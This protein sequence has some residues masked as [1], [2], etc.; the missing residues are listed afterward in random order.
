MRKEIQKVVC[1][2]N[3]GARK[4][5]R[6]NGVLMHEDTTG[7]MNEFFRPL[8]EL[9]GAIAMGS[10][11][12]ISA[13][14]VLVSDTEIAT[15]VRND[16]IDNI[17]NNVVITVDGKKHHFIPIFPRSIYNIFY[18]F[19]NDFL[20]PLFHSFLGF[21]DY[22]FDNKNRFRIPDNF[23]KNFE[24][25][26]EK[27]RQVANQFVE[28]FDDQAVCWVHDY[29]FLLIPEY[30]R[31]QRPNQ[32]V[33]FFLHIPFPPVE[34][35]NLF[36]RAKK[37]LSGMLGADYI[38]FHLNCYR[39]NF[40]ST[41]KRF[42]SENIIIKEDD[43][44]IYHKDQKTRRIKVDVNPIGIAYQ[45]HSG[46]QPDEKLKYTLDGLRHHNRQLLLSMSR[47]DPPKGILEIL[48][49]IS[50]LL[51]EY[52]KFVGAFTLVLQVIPSRLT[53]K[54]YTDLNDV[55]RIKLNEINIKYETEDWVPIYYINCGIS[56]EK[57]K[58]LQGECD[59]C[60]VP[61]LIDGFNLV[62][63]ET[64]AAH[65]RSGRPFAL[66]LSEGTGVSQVLPKGGFFS[67]SKFHEREKYIVEI[68]NQLVA[69]L[70]MST[71]EKKR[72]TQILQADVKRYRKLK[73]WALSSVE[74]V[75]QAA[76]S[77]NNCNFETWKLNKNSRQNKQ[78]Q[79]GWSRSFLPDLKNE[80]GSMLLPDEKYQIKN[81]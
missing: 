14:N 64:I 78:V 56:F 61:T 4:S 48:D 29:H 8:L 18:N 55:I 34:I 42:F 7:W 66:I 44:L 31:Q 32:S 57:I 2:L 24:I 11:G 54:A 25:Y 69:A 33:G 68:K 75:Y 39:Q 12:I 76:K 74:S 73:I 30:V 1:I 15:Y 65:E 46:F 80:I 67:V 19:S 77:R 22:F 37:L 41:V 16:V 79:N 51:K 72:R 50:L 23:D 62:T 53:V 59:I 26:C 43:D 9:Y 71:E 5:F 28:N 49:A 21:Q 40:L 36:P 3:N 60:M 27:N 47:L 63:L 58:T 70:Q 10:P 52:P 13:D 81:Q 45:K 6:K 20:W 17:L 35:F 38:A